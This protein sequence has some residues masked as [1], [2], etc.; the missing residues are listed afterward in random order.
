MKK[1]KAGPVNRV[2]NQIY[3]IT[4]LLT[5][6]ELKALEKKETTEDPS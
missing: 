2:F 1:K 6:D 5:D 3:K 4:G